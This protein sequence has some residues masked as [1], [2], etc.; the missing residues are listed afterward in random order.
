M[1]WRCSSR[2]AGLVRAGGG[3]VVFVVMPLTRPLNGREAQSG[4]GPRRPRGRDEGALP[5]DGADPPDWSWPKTPVIVSLVRFA[6]SRKIRRWRRLRDA[7]RS[8]AHPGGVA[9]RSSGAQVVQPLGAC[10]ELSDGVRKAS[11]SSS[12]TYVEAE[13]SRIP[14]SWSPRRPGQ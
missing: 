9:N 8:R 3:G 11:R 4:F 13:P 6:W 14:E 2:R 7:L 5:V 12:A 1:I 10:V